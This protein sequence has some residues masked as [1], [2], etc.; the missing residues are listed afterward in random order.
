MEAGESTMRGKV[1][2]PFWEREVRAVVLR[3][4]AR[5]RKPRVWK[6][7]ARLWPMPEEQPVIRTVWRGSGRLDIVRVVVGW[8]DGGVRVLSMGVGAGKES[9]G[10][11]C[12]LGVT[13]QALKR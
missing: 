6:E 5:T 2:M 7:R 8:W 12:G 1:S 10:L 3:A 9:S 4:V 11:S 13:Q